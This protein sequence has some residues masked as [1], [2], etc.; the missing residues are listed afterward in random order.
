GLVGPVDHDLSVELLAG[1]VL[2]ALA[3]ELLAELARGLLDRSTPEHGRARGRRLAGVELLDRVDHHVDPIRREPE[4]LAGDL[5]EH[6]VRSL[7][8]L[9]P[10]V[11]QRHAAVGLGPQ[12]RAPELEQPVADPRVLDAAADPREPSGAV[13]VAD[14]LE[15]GLDAD[16]GTE[17]LTGP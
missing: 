7:S 15:T 8:H 14:G 5:L 16:P 11:E 10:G 3:V 2:Q 4:L 1:E 17:H 6:G 9:G 12:D 13:G